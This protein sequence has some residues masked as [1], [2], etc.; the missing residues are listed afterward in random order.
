MNKLQELIRKLEKLVEEEKKKENTI[1]T[2]NNVI[3]EN[4]VNETLNNLVE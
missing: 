1:T 3:E 4:I 2:R